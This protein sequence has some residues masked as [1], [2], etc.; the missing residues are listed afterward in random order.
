MIIPIH[1]EKPLIK[2]PAAPISTNRSTNG[3]RTQ[4]P[5]RERNFHQTLPVISNTRQE[6]RSQINSQNSRYQNERINP[7]TANKPTS[8]LVSLVEKSEFFFHCFFFLDNLRKELKFVQ[9]INHVV[10]TM[11]I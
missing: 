3:F 2:Y 6:K 10:G 11:I 9:Q 4:K 8:S 5:H 7:N 1:D